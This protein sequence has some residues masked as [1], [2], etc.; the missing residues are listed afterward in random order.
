MKKPTKSEYETVEDFNY[1]NSQY[2]DYKRTEVL[3]YVLC[4][5]SGVIAGGIY[6][7]LSYLIPNF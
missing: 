5:I 7:V 2:E 3:A 4:A 6:V 1:R